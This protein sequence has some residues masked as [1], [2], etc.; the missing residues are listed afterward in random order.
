MTPEELQAAIEA[1]T[2]A[3][4]ML[5]TQFIRPATQQAF[6]NFERLQR[7][8]AVVES[9]VDLQQANAQQ[10]ADIAT[11]QQANAQQIAAN[12][13]HLTQIDNRLRAYDE[14]L[15]ET[16]QLVAQNASDIAQMGTR[17][18]QMFIRMDERLE[19]IDQLQADARR[20]LTMLN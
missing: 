13:E 8:E 17:H 6:A 9:T 15:E 14:R 2:A 4:N 1:N 12:T 3:I 7:L 19:R 11:Q 10:I 20:S 16:R 5:V 18:D